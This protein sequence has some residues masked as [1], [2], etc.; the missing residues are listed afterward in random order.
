MSPSPHLDL[1]DSLAININLHPPQNVT[2]I[3]HVFHSTVAKSKWR[4]AVSPFKK[5]LEHKTIQY[6]GAILLII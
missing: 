6:M 2:F 4:N 5:Y 1:N 3:L